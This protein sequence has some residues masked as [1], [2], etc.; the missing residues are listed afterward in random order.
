MKSNEKKKNHYT[1]L[2]VGA[3]SG[4]MS[5]Y[6]KEK[7]KKDK[8]IFVIATDPGQW[9]LTKHFRVE[10]YTYQD[11]IKTFQPNMVLASWMPLG[12]DWTNVM[13]RCESLEEYLL[14]GEADGGCCGCPWRTWGIPN[15]D[16]NNNQKSKKR[17]RQSQI[18]GYER[19]GFLKFYLH[20]DL[21]HTKVLNYRI[22]AVNFS[23]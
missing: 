18:P 1:V 23:E 12:E 13:R 17:K 20:C 14:I 3:G 15:N 8:N 6:L 16:D 22:L 7:L 2:E 9:Q 11:A 10:P 4:R 21:Y 19:D 5:Y